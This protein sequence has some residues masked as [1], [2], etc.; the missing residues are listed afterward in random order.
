MENY[1]LTKIKNHFADNSLA[2]VKGATKKTLQDLRGKIKNGSSI[3]IATGSRGID[4]L[5]VVIREVVQFV[6]DQGGNPFIVPAMGS[7]GGATAH[8]QEEV[9]AGYGI[10]ETAVGAPVKSSMNVVELP[11]DGLEHRIYMDKY[12]YESDGIILINKIKPHTDFH[13]TY[14]SGL[15]KMAVIGLGKEMGAEAI[16]H[17]G[18]YGLTQLI[19]ESAKKIFATNKIIAGIAV[20]ENAHDKTMMIKSVI[21]AD[22]MDKE[23]KL[24]EIARQNRPSFPVDKFDV[25]IIDKM[26]KNISGVGIDTNIV[27][28]LKIYGQKEPS[29][30]DI[31]SI[32]V[33]DITDESHGNATGVGLADIITRRLF[34]KIDFSS[35]YK[36]I[37][38]SS[39]LER[40]KIPFI[41]EH[42][43]SA[44]EL[45]LR[46]CGN[47]TPG[48][49][50]IIRI[51]DTLHLDELYV[52][53]NILNEIA[54]NPHIEVVA[55]DIPLFSENKQ[56]NPF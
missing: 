7:H 5:V 27:G 24:L 33:A 37:A 39:F 15:V 25:L 35:T 4:N 9:L 30:P 50:R 28:R 12:A 10:T 49:E 53:N 31:K 13:A 44:L 14:E 26:G 20:L 52:S 43:V 41:T 48:G 34:D 29:T 11:G 21:G 17:Y 55:K 8:G 46:N 51:K 18:V 40:G 1:T 22:I 38:T 45:A 56:F 3:A 6:K 2:D 54:N 23:P 16:H 42:D 32:V 36:N 19:P 47:A